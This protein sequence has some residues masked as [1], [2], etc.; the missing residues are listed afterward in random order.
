MPP[1]DDSFPFLQTGF[2]AIAAAQ[3]PGAIKRLGTPATAGL[4]ART[5]GKLLGRGAATAV[6]QFVPG[7]N[8][9]LDAWLIYDALSSLHEWIRGKNN[10]ASM[11]LPAMGPN[12]TGVR[13]VSGP[14]AGM[15]DV[16]G[17]FDIGAMD[18]I[19]NNLKQGNLYNESGEELSPDMVSD[20]FAGDYGSMGLDPLQADIQASDREYDRVLGL[21]YF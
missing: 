19:L 4:A 16:F 15:G 9:A 6:G 21:G 13:S 7:L 11:N 17:D 20:E 2:G 5:A 14:Q 3:L 10:K 8:I 1:E 18:S 12:V